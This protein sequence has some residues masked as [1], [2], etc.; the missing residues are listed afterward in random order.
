MTSILHQMVP[1]DKRIIYPAALKLYRVQNLR[2]G[3]TTAHIAR[4]SVSDYKLFVRLG[5][6]NLNMVCQSTKPEIL[7]THYTKYY[8]HPA[9]GWVK[10]EW[11]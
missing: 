6:N 8:Q 11:K 5:S 10:P 2:P 1:P 7:K 4:Y 9:E 3:I